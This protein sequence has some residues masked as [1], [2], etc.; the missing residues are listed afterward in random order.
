VESVFLSFSFRDTTQA[1]RSEIESVFADQEVRPVTGK[2]LEGRE[3][4]PEIRRLIDGADAFV[5]L[6]TPEAQLPSGKFQPTLWVYHELEIARQ[7]KKLNIALKHIEVE[8]PPG[9]YEYIAWD[10]QN[11]CPALLRL[12]S[13]LAA[14]RRSLGYRAKVRILP[15]AIEPLIG[16]KNAKVRYRLSRGAGG[17]A[18]K[19]RPAVLRSEVGGTFAHLSG[20]WTDAY[21]EIMIEAEGRRWTSKATPQWLHVELAEGGTP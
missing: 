16:A 8:A 18:G 20:V 4:T 5:C 9:E 7:L 19:W 11:T 3:P 10:P 1:F 6:L 15:T 13:T 21:I 17:E 14:W 12:Q 2:I